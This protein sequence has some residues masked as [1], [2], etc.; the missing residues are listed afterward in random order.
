MDYA[1]K[2]LKEKLAARNSS[3]KRLET[4]NQQDAVSMETYKTSKK[5]ITLQIEALK[6]AIA[7]IT[8]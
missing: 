6:R 8:E 2:V 3:L 1:V 5:M 4:A 7:M